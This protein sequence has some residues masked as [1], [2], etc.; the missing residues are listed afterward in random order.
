MSN[1]VMMRPVFG[2]LAA[3]AVLSAVAGCRDGTRT[4]SEGRGART[5]SSARASVSISDM[6]VTRMTGGRESA[7]APVVAPVTARTTGFCPAIDTALVDE[8]RE[9]FER[10][11]GCYACHGPDGRGSGVAPG[12]TGSVWLDIDG[13]YPAIA[14]VVQDGVVRP[15]RFPGPMPAMGGAKLDGEQVC[16]VAAYVFSLS[17]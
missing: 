11:G 4:Q 1:R 2:Y 3:L 10:A 15:R 12:L 13:S 9:V 5:L 17:H 7:R 14:E 16:A 8:G 6:A